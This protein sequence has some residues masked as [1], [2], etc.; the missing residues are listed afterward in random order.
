MTDYDGR[1]TMTVEATTRVNIFCSYYLWTLAAV[2]VVWVVVMY[3]SWYT[4]SSHVCVPLDDSRIFLILSRLL[5][6]DGFNF[7]LFCGNKNRLYNHC[8]RLNR[9]KRTDSITMCGVWIF[10]SMVMM[11]FILS[12][13]CV[14]TAFVCLW[15]SQFARQLIIIR[16]T[17]RAHDDTAKAVAESQPYIR[18][19]SQTSRV[20]QMHFN[21]YCCINFIPSPWTG[22]RKYW[23][24]LL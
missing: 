16:I 23:V 19:A 10:N 17:K 4:C 22:V 24:L 2:V 5:F 1:E 14:F 15:L 3:T 20:N 13:A 8:L 9:N 12:N 21:V 11:I 18:S 7:L 6:R